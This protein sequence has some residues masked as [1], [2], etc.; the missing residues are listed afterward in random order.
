[1]RRQALSIV[2]RIAKGIGAV[3]ILLLTLFVL[4]YIFQAFQRPI[5][6]PMTQQL[7]EGVTYSRHVQNMPRRAV[8]HVVEFDPTVADVTLFTTP[9]DRKTAF[10]HLQART[11]TQF[12]D[13]FGADVAI[14][15]SFF[16]PIEYSL[17]NFYPQVGDWVSSVGL[18]IANGVEFSAEDDEW[19]HPICILPERIVIQLE[20]CPSNTI[21]AVSGSIILLRDGQ[22]N[23]QSLAF[24]SRHYARTIIATETTG[25]RVWLVVAD[26]QQPGYSRGMT[27]DDLA[28]F[29][30]ERGATDAINLDGGGSATLVANGKLLNSPAQNLIPMRQRPVANHLG[31]TFR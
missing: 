15:A 11:T 14:N 5:R 19:F 21:N 2:W 3:L 10:N 8:W 7:H 22:L 12:A 1:M 26:G 20:G 6:R 16:F 28:V 24:D 23:H 17:H 31:I 30:L 29:L 25:Q 18:T 9:P 4:F 27:L 13:E